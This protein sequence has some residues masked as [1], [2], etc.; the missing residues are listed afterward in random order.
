VG[1][2]T[3][4]GQGLTAQGLLREGVLCVQGDREERRKS[5]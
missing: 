2:R 1:G 5:S 3:E 4:A